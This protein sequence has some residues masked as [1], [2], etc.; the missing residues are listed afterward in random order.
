MLKYNEDERMSWEELFSIP[1]FQ[2]NDEFN[3]KNNSLLFNNDSNFLLT[4]QY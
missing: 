1:E 2:L 4:N 3:I